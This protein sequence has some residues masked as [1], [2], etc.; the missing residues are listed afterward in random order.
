MFNLL[1]WNFLD[2]FHRNLWMFIAAAASLALMAVVPMTDG[3]TNGMLTFGSV[4][5]AGVFLPACVVLAMYQCFSWLRHDSALL[6]LSVP[7]SAWKQMLSRVIMAVLINLMTCLAAML[8]LILIYKSNSGNWDTL[9][10][11]HWESMGGLVLFL[12]VGDMTVLFSYMVSRGMGLTGL[13]SALITT[14][15]TTILTIGIAVFVVKAMVWANVLILPT[16]TGQHIFTMNGNLQVSSFL[17]AVFAGLWVILLE[18]LGSS[19]LLK[20][21]LQVE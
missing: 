11:E 19:L 5:L 9:T 20:Y 2:F 17:P 16:F 15:L 18:Y 6:E 7:A 12:L 1:K 13:W 4:M 10:V 14:L 8:M 3:I 21:S